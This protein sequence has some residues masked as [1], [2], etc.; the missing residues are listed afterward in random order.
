MNIN[1]RFAIAALGGVALFGKT[2][3]VLAAPDQ[4]AARAFIENLGDQAIDILQ[5]RTSTDTM[6][7]EFR[8]LFRA[9]FD[10]PTIGRFVLGRNWRQA[11]EE[12]QREYLKLIEDLVIETYS[13]RFSGYSGERFTIGSTRPQGENDVLVMSQIV[14][15]DGPPINVGW[16]VRDRSGGYRIIDVIVEQISMGVTYR[17]EFNS[18]I[19]RNGGRIEALLDALREEI[20]NT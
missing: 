3:S 12:Q 16:R 19:Q 13:R 18:I 20:A 9:S 14:R 8:A 1:R 5:R 17:D 6:T 4:T 11:T 2:A 7:E 10:I 15:P